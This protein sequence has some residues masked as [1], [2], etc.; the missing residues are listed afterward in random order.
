MNRT[1]SGFKTE[2]NELAILGAPPAFDGPRHVGRPNIVGRGQIMR[3]FEAIFDRMWLTNDGQVLQQFEQR[4]AAYSQ[5]E[6]CVAT[7]NGTIALQL[8]A[9]SLD[10]AGE[11]IVPSLTF[12]ATP[13]ALLGRASVPYLRTSIL[14]PGRWTPIRFAQD[15][16]ADNRHPRCSFVGSGVRCGGARRGR[17]SD[18]LELMFD[19]SHALGCVQDGVRVGNFG[20]AETLSFH[21]TKFV[22]AAE[23]GAILTNDAKLADRLRTCR[24]F[25]F[26]EPGSVVE[27]GTN[28]K[29][30]EFS[31]AIGLASLDHVTEIVAINRNNEA[32]YRLAIDR[33]PGLHIKAFNDPEPSNHQYVV[34]EVDAGHTG[35]TRDE[36]LMVLRAENVLARRYSFRA[37]IGWRPTP[38]IPSRRCLTP[39][40]LCNAPSPCQP[41]WRSTKRTSCRSSVSWSWHCPIPIASALNCR[42]GRWNPAGRRWEPRATA[43]RR[44]AA[45]ANFASRGH[46]LLRLSVTVDGR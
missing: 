14:E 8:A 45:R 13:H 44:A 21:A 32:T 12:V 38:P 27:I 16:A 11:V 23:G 33:L 28:A 18:Q 5:V 25:G 31:A 29:M 30:S 17:G 22:N 9:R 3:Q 42:A 46:C 15:H 24:N 40:R 19:A 7:C 35:L 6:H 43:D 20:R 1:P 41:G 26:A 4:V 39:R 34:M 37:V 2:L 10:L 36:L